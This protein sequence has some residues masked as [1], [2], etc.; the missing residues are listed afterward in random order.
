MVRWLTLW[1]GVCP[2]WASTAWRPS[3]WPHP[4]STLQHT[5]HNLS[6][7][8]NTNVGVPGGSLHHVYSQDLMNYNQAMCGV[9]RTPDIHL[10][11][12]VQLV[13]VVHLNLHTGLEVL[14]LALG[15]V[16][17]GWGLRGLWTHTTNNT[18]TG[19]LL[20]HSRHFSSAYESLL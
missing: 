8:P 17:L 20:S 13:R 18:L 2:P 15:D 12:R 1:C 9:I 4:P 3:S 19:G 14:K 5:P 7:S 10:C 6:L 16:G 11:H